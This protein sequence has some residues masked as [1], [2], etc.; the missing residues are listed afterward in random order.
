MPPLLLLWVCAAAAL[1]HLSSGL[2]TVP[3]V[4][5]VGRF[6]VL[7]VDEEQQQQQPQP[8]KRGD[9]TS[10]IFLQDVS[11]GWGNGQH[12]T[13]KLCLQFIHDNVKSGDVVLDYGTGSGVLS[14]LSKALGARQCVAVDIDEDS[15][16][17]AE[18][19]A[20][21]NGWSTPDEIL[22]IH[23]KYIYLGNDR[24]PTAD[25]AVA[26]ILPGPLTRLVAPLW[27]LT[28]PGGLLCLSGMRPAELPAVRAAYEPFVDL[29]TERV[30]EEG[31]AS[32]GQWVS[33]AVR[34]KEMGDEERRAARTRLME[35]AMG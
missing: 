31:H 35:Q 15:L 23:T 8:D 2:A 29:S 32:F 30:C 21:L 17:A 34:F 22:V 9:G 20:Q 4:V 18:R 28:K 7:A 25:V 13:T 16:R 33:W 27:G 6:E 10:R 26:N 3:S 14:L 11:S 5:R 1:L 19:N 24:I 12:P